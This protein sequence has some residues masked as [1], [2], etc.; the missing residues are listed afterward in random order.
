VATQADIADL[1]GVSVQNVQQVIARIMAV[2]EVD[3]STRNSEFLVRAEAQ[4][5]RF[6]DPAVPPFSATE[7]SSRYLSG[8][9]FCYA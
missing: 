8:N 3:E 1:S 9:I 2:S 7:T 5:Q 6:K 4:D